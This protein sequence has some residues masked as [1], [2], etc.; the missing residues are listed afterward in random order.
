M[1]LQIY[2]PRERALVRTADAALGVVVTMARALRRRARAATPGRILLLRLERIGDLLMSLPGI[3]GVREL[4]PTAQIDLVVGG[5]NAELARAIPFVDRV[6]RLDAAWLSREGEGRS[7]GA[8]LRTARGWRSQHYDIGINFEPDI[9]S[10]LLLAASGAQWTAG[11]SSGGGGPVLDQALEFEPRSHTSE[12]ALRLVSAVFGVTVSGKSA[13]LKVPEDER[14]RARTILGNCPRPLVA[15]HVSGGRPVKQWDPARFADVAL[16]LVS[17]RGATLLLTGA[18]ADAPLI[19]QVTR[20]LPEG[21]FIDA[22]SGVNVLTL[23]ALLEQSDLMVTGDTGPMHVAAAVGTPIVAVFGPSDPRR[24]A[25]NGS[26]DRIV[27][28]DLPCAPCNR[29]RLPPARCTG[30]IPDCLALVSADRVYEAAA[31]VL[32]QCRPSTAQGASA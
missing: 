8:L 12:N 30:V 14:L 15:M 29:I 11:Y 25:P 10:N 16:R 20:T 23:A 32:D 18:P 7:F 4:A 21:S 24:Y 27:R 5:W 2:D 28:V 22:S 6:I 31:G 9:R 17:S 1:S 13:V 19:Q 26:L 3:A